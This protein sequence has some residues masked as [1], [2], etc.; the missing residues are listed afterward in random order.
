MEM[1]NDVYK[2]A[3]FRID[4]GMFIHDRDLN[5]QDI[6]PAAQKITGYSKEDVIGKKCTVVFKG[7]LCDSLCAVCRDSNNGKNTGGY[8]THI[9]LKDGRRYMVN[10]NSYPLKTDRN[11]KDYFLVVVKDVTELNDL[12]EKFSE[13]KSFHNIVGKNDKM[14]EIYGLVRNV[15]E[16]DSTVLIYGE[17]GTG[18]EL[19]A[20]AIHYSSDRGKGEFVRINC[21][22]LPESLLESE[23]FGHVKGAFTGAVRDRIGRFES[24]S[25]GTVFLDE[26][27]DTTP[28][29]QAKLLRVLQ[30]HE[31]ERVGDNMPRKIDVRVLAATNKNLINLLKQNKFREDLYFRLSVV[32][33]ELPPLRERQDDIT[34]LAEHFLADLNKK[35]RRKKVRGISSDAMKLLVV[36][37]WPGNIRELKNALEHAFVFCKNNFIEKKDLPASLASIDLSDEITNGMDLHQIPEQERILKTLHLCRWNVK[38]AAEKLN[39]SRTTLWRKMKKFE[40]H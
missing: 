10:V 26:V 14:R 29:F 25:G 11:E 40:I 21:A 19:I 1:I 3:F 5:I 15:A 16:T 28:A 2:S 17:T 33:I 20:A 7:K 34:L 9:V 4:L 27:G 6:N 32:T 39:I 22:A 36:Y 24:A 31:I 12:K 8:E 23:L 18:K 37:P 38:A 35:S 30:E 13:T